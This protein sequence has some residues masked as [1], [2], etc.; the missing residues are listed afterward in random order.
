MTGI[1]KCEPIWDETGFWLM[2]GDTPVAEVN[3]ETCSHLDFIEQWQES[4]AEVARLK[5]ELEGA[6]RET[7]EEAETICIQVAMRYRYPVDNIIT[8]ANE[9]ARRIR[10]AK[11]R[12]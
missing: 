11:E 10:E 6:R 9:C 7:W 2:D 4:R 1:L 8:G 5:A 12:I 3:V